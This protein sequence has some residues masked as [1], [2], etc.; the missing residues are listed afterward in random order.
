MGRMFTGYFGCFREDVLFKAIIENLTNH[1]TSGWY[2]VCIQNIHI[3]VL[4]FAN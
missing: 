3:I 1:E 4:Y 2:V